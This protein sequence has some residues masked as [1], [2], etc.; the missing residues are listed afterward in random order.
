MGRAG[1]VACCWL[2]KL[3]LCGWIDED[4]TSL[5]TMGDFGLSSDNAFH[6][7]A[8]NQHH[9]GDNSIPLNPEV[10]ALVQRVISVIRKRRSIKAI[11]T[12]EQVKFLVD[13]VEFL[14]A[15]SHR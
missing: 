15:G 12:Y 13:Y 5:E 2:I 4:N 14:R 6:N 1:V 8:T 11:E 9:D 3:G 10:V 7:L